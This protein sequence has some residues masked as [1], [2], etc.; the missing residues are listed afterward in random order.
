MF[1]HS[2]QHQIDVVHPFPDQPF[3]FRTNPRDAIT[4]AFNPDRR[5]AVYT[6]VP[7]AGHVT[8]LHQQ[9][10]FNWTTS[11][12]ELLADALGPCRSLDPDGDRLG[13][14][15]VILIDGDGLRMF[16]VGIDSDPRRT[17]QYRVVETRVPGRRVDGPRPDLTAVSREL[18]GSW[19][20]DCIDGAIARREGF[21]LW[22]L[23]LSTSLYPTVSTAVTNGRLEVARLNHSGNGSYR[24]VARIPFAAD[25]AAVA[26]SVTL[27]ELAAQAVSLFN[28]WPVF[29]PGLGDTAIDL[30]AFEATSAGSDPVEKTSRETKSC[31]P[32]QSRSQTGETK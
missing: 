10:I 18:L 5:S 19:I 1:P 20:T 13:H 24:V 27:D 12:P 2:Q 6:S 17:G 31:K 15:S 29:R 23:D 16:H 4:A 14:D 30:A 28:V 7:V 26:S 8:V 25:A 9:A 3:D 22:P 11:E 32:R 21:E